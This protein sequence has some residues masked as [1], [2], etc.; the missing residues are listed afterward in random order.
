MPPGTV[1][2]KTTNI[3]E[4]IQQFTTSCKHSTKKF[5]STVIFRQMHA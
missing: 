2:Q 3:D 1:Y 4:E 5:R